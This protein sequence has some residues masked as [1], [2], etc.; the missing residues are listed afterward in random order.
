MIGKH[1]RRNNGGTGGATAYVSYSDRRRK[2]D[3]SRYIDC[4]CEHRSGSYAGDR[5]LDCGGR[6]QLS[7]S[8]TGF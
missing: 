7:A 8:A 2:G 3:T 5:C 1:L 6:V 4:V